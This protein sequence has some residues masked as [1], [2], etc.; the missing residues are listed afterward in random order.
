MCDHVFS[1]VWPLFR[2]WKMWSRN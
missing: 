1:V 2:S